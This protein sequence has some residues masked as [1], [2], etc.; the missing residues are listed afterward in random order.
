MYAAI[1]AGKRLTSNQRSKFSRLRICA[2]LHN[3]AR[4]ELIQNLSNQ[5]DSS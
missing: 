1:A 4:E 3:G 2:L 5:L